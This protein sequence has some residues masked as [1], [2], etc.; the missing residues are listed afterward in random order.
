M[1]VEKIEQFIEAVKDLPAA[2]QV[3][4][5]LLTA[6][7]D[8]NADLDEVGDI[9]SFDPALTT[10]LLRF[11]NSAFFAGAE[12]VA[13]VPEAIGRVG[14]ESLYLLT[15]AACGAAVF[16]LPSGCGVD[17]TDLWKHSLLSAFGTKF[18]AESIAAD[19]NLLFTGGLLHD[20]GRIIFARVKGAEY[21]LMVQQ[22]Q[23][24][25]INLAQ[26]ERELFGFDHAEVSAGLMVKWKI[27]GPLIE[28]V[29]YHHR[30]SEAGPIQREA[31]CVCVGN[32]LAHTMGQTLV[33][34]ADP[35]DELVNSMN[36]LGINPENMQDFGEQMKENWEFVNALLR[37]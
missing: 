29:R 30:P 13:T 17:S 22:A 3:L 4:P 26:L 18:V 2:P 11:C 34:S 14:F 8:D 23:S 27:P 10:R 21:G 20:V 33:Y 24:E 6:L 25:G 15:T 7:N 31:A 1:V 28:C 32:V 16:T 5:R 37:C 35:L 19:N 36:L 12:P 9:I